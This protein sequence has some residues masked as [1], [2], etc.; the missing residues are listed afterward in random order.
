MS[1]F[2]NINVAYVYVKNWEETK[3]FY[4]EILGW[5]IAFGDDSIG[6]FEYGAENA[7]HFA[8]SR[9]DDAD[10]DPSHDLGTTIVFTVDDATSATKALREKG[11]RC[12]DPTT[13]PGIVTY[14]T[15]YDP[16]GN[17]LQMASNG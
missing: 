12:D 16:E 8:I 15:F 14:G 4:G 9:W 6:W 2:K 13:I 1:L 3:K 7:A 10:T 17:R 11:V 5:P